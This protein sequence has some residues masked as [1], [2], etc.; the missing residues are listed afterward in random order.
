MPELTCERILHNAS[1][2]S[3]ISS[4]VQFS[5]W[6]PAARRLAPRELTW[7]HGLRIRTASILLTPLWN[8]A[9]HSCEVEA[10]TIA[11]EVGASSADIRAPRKVWVK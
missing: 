3:C 2:A 7:R 6:Q 10:D 5:V 11:F 8:A 1:A 9:T 4:R